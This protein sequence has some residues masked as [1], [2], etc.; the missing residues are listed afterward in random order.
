MR[1]ER[2]EL[3]NFKCYEDVDVRLDP[4]VTVIHGP[5]GS[6]KSSLLEASF[7]ALYGTSAFDRTLEEFV[8]IGSEEA[9]V[10][11]KFVHGGGDYHLHRRVRV[12]GD[13]AST[14]DCVPRGQS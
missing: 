11:L 10:D 14:P 2:I 7:F 13:R 6:G 1:F 3:R 12:S 4:G 8:T 5:N 9:S